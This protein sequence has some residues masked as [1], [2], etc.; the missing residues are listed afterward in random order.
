MRMHDVKY[1]SHNI[2]ED[3]EL[4]SCILFYYT[5]PT[6]HVHL[7]F[8]LLINGFFLAFLKFYKKQRFGYNFLYF[9]NLVTFPGVM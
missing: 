3:E 7:L 8:Q 1:D 6:F 4:R 9:A 5:S 2:L